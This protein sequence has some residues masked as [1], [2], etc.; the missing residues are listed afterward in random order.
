MS[1]FYFYDTIQ[2]YLDGLI[3][4]IRFQ[5][6]AIFVAK[7]GGYY[8]GYPYTGLILRVLALKWIFLDKVRNIL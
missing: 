5:E 1:F 7:T 2:I 8:K 4:E 6:V 3:P